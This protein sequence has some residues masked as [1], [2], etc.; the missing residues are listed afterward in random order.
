MKLKKKMIKGI[1]DNEAVQQ[2]IGG[3]KVQAPGLQKIVQKQ[4]RAKKKKG[5]NKKK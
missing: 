1:T 5:K 2:L 3:C 4:K